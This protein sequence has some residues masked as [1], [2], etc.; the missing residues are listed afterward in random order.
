MSF[1][2][3]F[4]ATMKNRLR[5]VLHTPSKLITTLIF[6]ALLVVSGLSA[7]GSSDG[8][9]QRDV[10]EL[11][12]LVLALYATVFVLTLSHAFGSGAS[13]YSM[14]DVHFLFPAPLSARHVLFY[15]LIRQM[16][17]SLLI[18]FFLLFQYA[19]L[20]GTYGLKIG[21]LLL[22]LLGYGACMFCAQLGAMTLY[23]LIS[24]SEKARRAAKGAL[25]AVCALFAAALIRPLFS[26]Q[27]DLL[28]AL[29]RSANAPLLSLF[30]IAGWLRG[31]V[32]AWIQGNLTAGFLY[33]ALTALASAALI[34]IILRTRADF[35]EDVLAATEST[36]SAI[37][38]KKEGMF[39]EAAPRHVRVGGIGIGKGTG[40]SV[41]YHKHLLE[42]RR[43]RFLLLDGTAMMFLLINW[44]FAYFTR[45]MGLLPILVF[46]VYLQIFSVATGRWVREL[47]LPYV[48]LAPES[49]FR[50]LF[51]ICREN[52]LK[53]AVEAVALFVPVALILG[54]SPVE[55]IACILMR[56]GFGLLFIAGNVLIE[57]VLGALTNKLVIMTLY[58]LIMAVICI[59]GVIIGAILSAL[60][61]AVAPALAAVA[62][63]NAACAALIVFLCRDILDCAELNN[64]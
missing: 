36:H 52:I 37:T 7:A 51:H 27:S 55:A 32:S 61:G 2:Y 42:D 15:G 5:E 49:S 10:S 43:S 45:S 60:L 47:I 40:A 53:T 20:H 58:L 63:W 33:A 18:G 17:T 50:K 39:A 56:I 24:G 57:R 9:A 30:P 29:V 35:Y 34:F 16:G 46:S 19:W 59:P 12:A 13:F 25:I 3:L 8:F 4:S 11:Y 23:S 21:G 31:S 44:I 28:G 6:A 26:E 64:R 38:A 48:Y 62:V 14:A 54:L 22:I 1:V 41:F